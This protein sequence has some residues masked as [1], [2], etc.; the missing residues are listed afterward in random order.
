MDATHLVAKAD[1]WQERD[2]I[3]KAKLDK[4]NN[5]TIPKVAITPAN[6]TD[7]QGLKHVT[8]E[9]GAIYADKGYCTKPARHAAA[10]KTDPLGYY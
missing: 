3:I 1:L 9:S 5:I 2:K 10:K 7:A 6:V 8:P 4:L